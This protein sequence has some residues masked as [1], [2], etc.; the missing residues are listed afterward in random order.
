M[1]SKNGLVKVNHIYLYDNIYKYD[2]KLLVCEKEQLTQ[3]FLITTVI[4]I[5]IVNIL[6]K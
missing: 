4:I 1:K 6:L 2:K 3:G 5:I